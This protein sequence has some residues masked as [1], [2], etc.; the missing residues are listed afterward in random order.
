MDFFIGGDLNIELMLDIA[1][2]E[3]RGQD[4]IE[5]FGMYGPEC[6]GGADDITKNIEVVPVIQRFQLH[7]DQHL[8]EE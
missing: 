1:E 3:Y 4:S 7:L 5:W 8:D 6:K 2:D